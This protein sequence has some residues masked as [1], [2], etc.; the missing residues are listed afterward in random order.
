VALNN[1]GIEVDSTEP[2]DVVSR[3]DI[4]ESSLTAKTIVVGG[5]EGS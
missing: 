3:W 1:I 2:Y 4:D 5:G